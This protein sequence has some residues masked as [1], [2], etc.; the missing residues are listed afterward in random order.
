[1]NTL[2]EQ[3]IHLLSLLMDELEFRY[4]VLKQDD[5][6]IASFVWH[7]I[8]T[9]H[10]TQDLELAFRTIAPPVEQIEQAA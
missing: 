5:Q 9:F 7:L 6:S 4:H 8:D 2:L 3:N 1:M 10:Q